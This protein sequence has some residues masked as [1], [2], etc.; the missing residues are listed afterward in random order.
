MDEQLN[1]RITLLTFALGKVMR[2]LAKGREG[3][4]ERIEQLR[5]FLDGQMEVARQR[6]SHPPELEF[7]QQAYMSGM[8]EE[9]ES[10]IHIIDSPAVRRSNG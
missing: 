7:E 8:Y 4:E 1:G 6:S 3:R 10:L 9:L 2:D 5:G